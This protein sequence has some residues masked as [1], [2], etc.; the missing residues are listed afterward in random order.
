MTWS[1]YG[2]GRYREFGIHTFRRFFEASRHGSAKVLVYAVFVAAEALVL[3][4][5]IVDDQEAWLAAFQTHERSIAEAAARS[6]DEHAR[7]AFFSNLLQTESSAVR[8]PRGVRSSWLKRRPRDTAEGRERSL[9]A[10]ASKIF[11]A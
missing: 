10:F 4:G 2:Q 1:E 6:A 7:S 3:L 8:L 11:P 9:L 5:A